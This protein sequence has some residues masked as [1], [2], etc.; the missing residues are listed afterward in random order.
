[1]KPLVLSETETPDSS[2]ILDRHRQSEP[3]WHVG[4]HLLAAC[5]EAVGNGF[6]LL[7]CSRHTS[8]NTIIVEAPPVE[9]QT[10][11]GCPLSRLKLGDCSC[12]FSRNR[13]GVEK[14]CRIVWCECMVSQK[15]G[16]QW[17]YST[18]HT[19]LKVAEWALVGFVCATCHSECSH[20]STAAKKNDSWAYLFSTHPHVSIGS[21]NSVLFAGP[22]RWFCDPQ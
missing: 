17:C 2:S 14:W 11:A 9:V 3:L 5:E 20:M 1:M 6:L 7:A 15:K 22:C 21:Q 16:S 12:S 4:L 13:S 8:Q 10:C 18:P 19:N